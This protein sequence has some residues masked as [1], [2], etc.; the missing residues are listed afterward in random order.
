MSAE[1]RRG[2]LRSRESKAWGGTVGM[3]GRNAFDFD[4]DAKASSARRTHHLRFSAKV[5]P[6]T[7]TF[8]N[9]YARL[10]EQFGAR[11][12]PTPVANPSLIVLNAALA[13]QLGL[14]VEWLAGESGLGML[15]GNDLPDGA[16][17]MAQAYAGHQFGQWVPQLGDGRALL[18][19]EVSDHDGQLRDIQ[20]KGSGPTP[21]SRGGDGRSSIGPVVREYLGSEAMAALGIA[22]TRA[23][24]AVSTGEMVQREQPEPGGILCRVAA[25]HVR[26]G[27]FEF[28]ARNGRSEDVRTLAD[29]VIQRHYPACADSD[30]PYSALLDQVLQRTA[31]LVAAWMSVGFVHGVMNTDNLAISGETLDYGPFGF[32]DTFAPDTAFSYIDRRGRYAWS[33]QPMIANWNLARLAECLLPLLDDD[34]NTATETANSLLTSFQPIFESAFHARLVAKIGLTE[35]TPTS[36]ELATHLLDRMAENKAD[37]TLLFRALSHLDAQTSEQDATARNLFSQPDSFDQWAENWRAALAADGQDDSQRQRA[38]QSVNP[39][40]I[41]RNHL[42]QRVANAAVNDL[43]FTPLHEML[44]VFSRPYEEQPEYAHFQQPPQPDEVVANTFCGT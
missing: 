37:M 5:N 40:F 25:S 42:A 16:E 41:L 26:I 20:L 43:D 32:L 7:P 3:C 12:N 4:F 14:D 34:P 33:R 9:S 44:K 18:L 27:T 17:P 15:S 35:S 23:L 13:E 10:P 1:K 30:Q 2:G 36:V 11:L 28:F 29:Y 21:F 8:D 38:M 39:A 22:T 6:M 24:A 31:S 19:G